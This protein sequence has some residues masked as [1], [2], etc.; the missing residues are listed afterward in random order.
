MPEPSSLNSN[1]KESV[2]HIQDYLMMLRNRWKEA[3]LVFLLVFISCA[4]LTRMMTPMY[5]T[6]MRFEIKM[7]RNLVDISGG[8]NPIIDDARNSSSYMQTQFELLVTEENLKAVA[9]RLGLAKEWGVSPKVAAGMLSGMI[10]IRPLRGTDLIDVVVTGG[11]PQLVQRICEAVPL[12]Y[13]EVREEKEDNLINRTIETRYALIRSRHDELERKADV[14]RQYIRSGQYLGDIWRQGASAPDSEF[15]ESRMQSLQSRKNGLDAEISTS[16]VHIN[17]LQRLS[18]EDLLGYVRRTG[19]LTAESYSSSRVR[20]LSEQYENEKESRRT[21]IM[22]GRGDDHPKIQLIDA[23]LKT[24]Q[25][26]LYTELIGMRDAMMDQLN[27][28]KAERA[29]VEKELNVEKEK[30]RGLLLENQKTMRALQEYDAEK[31]RYDQLENAYIADRIRLTAPRDTIVVHSEPA[32]PSAPSSPNYKLNLTI[33]AVVGL[34]AGVVVAFIYNYFDTSIK[35]LE[36]AERQLGLPVMGV[37][38][39]DAGLFIVQG[40]ESPDAEAYRILRTNIEL[41]KSLFK[42]SVYAI[43]S[44]NAG[45]GK[46]T[47]LSNLAY[48][49]AQSGYSTLMIDAD[50]RRPR[51]ASYSEI[52]NDHGLTNY[53]SQDTELKDV[54]F[55]TELS[56]LYILPSGP[57]A[58]DPSGLLA[59]YRMDRLLQEAA[60]R[61]DIVLVDSPPMLGVSDASLIVSKVD[62]TLIVLQPRKMPVK[63]LHRTKTLIEDAGGKIMGLVLNNVDISGDSQYQYY[64]TYYSY[65]TNDNKRPEP[66]PLAEKAKKQSAPKNTKTASQS[67]SSKK[68]AAASQAPASTPSDDDQ[69]LY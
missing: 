34:I 45:E 19:I 15:T 61:F 6:N 59:S 10:S 30:L 1:G 35:T 48:V 24:T 66:K 28:K 12:A 21:M 43:V 64:T 62:A 20:S 27:I 46:T 40:G 47:T 25:D 44:S 63:A 52:S 58:P 32:R 36:E 8:A 51:L 57:Q 22:E 14:L 33:G 67:P 9:T 16:E 65:Y 41:K 53:L 13:K 31:Q 50:L 18:D 55:K 4:V 29:A 11:D 7:P 37:I 49:C 38:P 2:L 42:S 56:N 3:F 68:T 60:R 54:I 23:Q 26:E 69:E 17:E 5:T 39:Q